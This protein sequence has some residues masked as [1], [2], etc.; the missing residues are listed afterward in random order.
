MGY[1]FN[2]RRDQLEGFVYPIDGM[3]LDI[4]SGEPVSADRYIEGFESDF[5]LGFPDKE[6]NEVEDV[7]E[8][9]DIWWGDGAIPEEE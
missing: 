8:A 9:W 3:Y 5:C 7:V 2:E 6:G 4:V 1:S